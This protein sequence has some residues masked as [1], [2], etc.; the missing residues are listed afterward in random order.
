MS[1]TETAV[2][3]DD[4]ALF[5]SATSEAAPEAPAVETP[6]AQGEQTAQSDAGPARDE[7]GRFA[8]KATEAEAP[9]KPETTQTE[10]PQTQADGI[11]SWRL[12]EEA[13]ARRRAEAEVVEARAQARQFQQQLQQFQK[14]PAP[15]PDMWENPD[16]FVE[17]GVKQAL[18]PVQQRMDALREHYSWKDAVR[19]HGQE[20]AVEARK[21]FYEA[22]Q[23]GE[24]SVGHVLQRALTSI[25]PFEDIVGAYKQHKAVATVGTDP[26]AWFQQELERRKASD[27]EFAAKH[28]APQQQ[29]QG[30]PPTNIV[31]LPPS[32][33]RQPGSAGN[34]DVGSM[35]DA[36]LFAQA[37]RK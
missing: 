24:Q 2:P 8:P 27:P 17:H 13:E 35:N 25:D 34:S 32:L 7:H 6:A 21:W 19:T 33:N 3:M 16:G 37:I 5:D 14:P 15:R 10:Q 26:E 12:K 28:L 36:D 29:A 18:D 11:P 23:R 1:E 31:K 20:T 30:A 22:V 9:A 4:K